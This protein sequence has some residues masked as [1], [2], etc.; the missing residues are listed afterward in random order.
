VYSIA[1]S[2]ASR[3]R[4]AA[5]GCRTALAADVSSRLVHRKRHWY[6]P[7]SI[8]RSIA[9]RPR[10]YFSALAGMV[11]LILLPGG[12]SAAIRQA[13]AWDLSAGIYLVMAFHV[14]LT[15]QG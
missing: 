5:D 7:K 15:V 1:A 4:M 11:A 2:Q 12:W 10:L 8:A 3:P 13:V 9:I 14:M 6:D